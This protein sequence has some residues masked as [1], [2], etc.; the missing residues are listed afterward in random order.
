MT[1]ISAVHKHCLKNVKWSV[2]W[3]EDATSAFM[4]CVSAVYM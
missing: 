3:T 4:L 2:N 1:M